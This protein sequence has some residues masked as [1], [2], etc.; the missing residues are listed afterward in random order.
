MEKKLKTIEDK[1]TIAS[2]REKEINF[3]TKIP[4]EIK[5]GE[6]E[7]T[8][9]SINALR[10]LL[11]SYTFDSDTTILNSEPKYKTILTEKETYIVKDKL[12]ELIKK[13]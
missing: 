11:E 1:L 3:K 5:H 2:I 6:I 9:D 8:I 13:L 4:S 7:K 10:Y 12:F